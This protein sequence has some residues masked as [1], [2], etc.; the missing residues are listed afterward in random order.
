MKKTIFKSL[1]TLIQVLILISLT[2]ITIFAYP[3]TQ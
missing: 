2:T 3:I 1:I